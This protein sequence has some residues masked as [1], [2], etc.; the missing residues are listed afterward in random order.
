MTEPDVQDVQKDSSPPDAAAA[1]SVRGLSKVYRIYSQPVDLIKE[2]FTGRSHHAEHWALKDVSFE[3]KRGEVVGVIGRNGAGKS[4]LLKILAGTLDKTAGDV[5]IQGSIAAILELGTGFHPEYTGR[6]NIYMGGMCLGMSREEIDRKIDSIIEFSE[7]ASVIDQKFRTYSSGMQARLTFSTAVSVE[8]DIFI[9]D[10]A[11][12][13]GDALFSEKCSRRIREI[14]SRG[15]T[16]FFCTHSMGTIVELCDTAILLSGGEL[17]LKDT[18]REVSY[19]YDRI[20]ADD[21]HLQM[22]GTGKPVVQSRRQGDG[23][24]EQARPGEVPADMKAELL[25]YG[26]Y[27]AQGAAVEFLAA[28]QEYT[29]RAEIQCYQ[30]LPNLGVGFRVETLNGT[31]VYGLQTALLDVNIP[32]Q[33]GQRLEVDFSF[34]CD[35]QAG[36]YVLGGGLAELRAAGGYSIIHVLRGA[37]VFNVVGRT[38]FTGLADLKGK[39]LSVR[40]IQE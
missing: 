18:P 25:S 21:R 2:I 22:K 35:L 39:L 5:D 26:I 34:P 7:L 27:N 31:P 32:C 16:V 19:A 23:A 3:V 13:A 10:E 15:A 37:Q 40:V 17:M 24:K 14:V 8:P 4:T 9:V 12:A 36:T 33:A 38:R 11:L 28:G 6:E 1:I 29:V 30:D 20:L